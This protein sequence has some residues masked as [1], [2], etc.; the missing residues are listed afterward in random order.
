MKN[1]YREDMEI[2]LCRLQDKIHSCF[3]LVAGLRLDTAPESM[4][5]AR[6]P[7]RAAIVPAGPAARQ[8]RA[9]T[10]RSYK[11]PAT[12]DDD[13][14]RLPARAAK[15]KSII[16]KERKKQPR[17]S[18]WE[19]FY[20]VFRPRVALFVYSVPLSAHSSASLAAFC[21]YLFFANTKMACFN[22]T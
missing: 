17:S 15:A 7:L 4:S 13:L 14:I 19:K 16:I 6:V 2:K 11:L 10:A 1:Q 9:R 3:I 18:D 21:W 5:A 20:A 22:Q 8:C 12:I